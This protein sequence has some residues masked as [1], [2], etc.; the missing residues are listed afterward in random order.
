LKDA[1]LRRLVAEVTREVTART[2]RAPKTPAA[3]R[4]R[5]G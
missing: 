1:D 3:S 2:E 5:N 4:S